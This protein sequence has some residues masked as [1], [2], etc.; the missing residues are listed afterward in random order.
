MNDKI[1]MIG[2][3]EFKVIDKKTGKKIGMRMVWKNEKNKNGA[4]CV[5]GWVFADHSEQ[6]LVDC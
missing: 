3:W 2:I 6:A 5:S 1:K 4:A